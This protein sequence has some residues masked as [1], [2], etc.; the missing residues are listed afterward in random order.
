MYLAC[1]GSSRPFA[2]LDV[3]SAYICVAMTRASTFQSY[4]P[5][6]S[7]YPL[8][9]GIAMLPFARFWEDRPPHTADRSPM[10]ALCFS[11]SLRFLFPSHACMMHFRTT[12]C[13]P[14][15]VRSGPHTA[16]STCCD[17]VFVSLDI[18]TMVWWGH[19]A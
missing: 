15:F 8:S 10:I 2:R 16:G 11:T 18:E 3:I 17:T 1:P 19:R 5:Y 6:R 13:P 7:T 12:H 14:T 9:S 4:H